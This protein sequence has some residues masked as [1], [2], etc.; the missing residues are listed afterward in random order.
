MI[1]NI[2]TVI[3]LELSILSF[4]SVVLNT[5]ISLWLKRRSRCSA[6]PEF[7]SSTRLVTVSVC[8]LS[9]FK[10]P[11]MNLLL[12]KYGGSSFFLQ[13]HLLVLGTESSTTEF[14]WTV[15]FGTQWPS[16]CCIISSCRAS[17]NRFLL[18]VSN[19]TFVFNPTW[20]LMFVLLHICSVVIAS[21]VLTG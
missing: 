15:F 11:L 14:L 1:K 8:L 12:L 9:T 4:F 5:C 21:L 16:M 13:I 3:I 7:W 17:Y 2:V 18:F 6:S 20:K 10:I 19:L